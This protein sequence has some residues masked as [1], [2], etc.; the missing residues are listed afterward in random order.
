MN[1]L[2]RDLD[3]DVLRAANAKAESKA[4]VMGSAKMRP[5]ASL[6]RSRPR[7]DASQDG[8]GDRGP[9]AQQEA[10]PAFHLPILARPG[11][12]RSAQSPIKKPP[13][14]WG[15]TRSRS[16]RNTWEA[17]SSAWGSGANKPATKGG[18]RGWKSWRDWKKDGGKDGGRR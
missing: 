17:S 14:T 8:P 12:R 13:K 9:C 16:P 7:G 6:G 5:G 10:W 1:A 2:L 11:A 15:A 18:D 3:W 4:K